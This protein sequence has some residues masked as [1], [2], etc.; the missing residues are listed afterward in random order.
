MFWLGRLY[1]PIYG[2]TQMYRKSYYISPART[3]TKFYWR[4]AAWERVF[5]PYWWLGLMKSSRLP[6]FCFVLNFTLDILHSGAW[7]RCNIE[8]N[9]IAVKLTLFLYS[10]VV[11]VVNMSL[12]DCGFHCRELCDFGTQDCKLKYSMLTNQ[13]RIILSMQK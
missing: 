1:G 13:I 12:C 8:D 7:I 10:V 11:L 3:D 6:D 5:P 4:Y 9:A 2:G